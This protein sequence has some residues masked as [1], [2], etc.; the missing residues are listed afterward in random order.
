MFNGKITLE[1]ADNGWLIS[2]QDKDRQRVE[3]FNDDFGCML[4][5]CEL[6]GMLAGPAAARLL[7]GVAESYAHTDPTND[8]DTLALAAPGT[9]ATVSTGD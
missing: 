6:A 1:S 5:L 8:P 3:V 7:L 2:W 9:P 4:R